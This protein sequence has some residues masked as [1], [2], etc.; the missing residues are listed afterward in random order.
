M[1][2]LIVEDDADTRANLEDILSLDG[3]CVR[4]AGSLKEA[5]ARD[6][7]SEIGVVLLDRKLP[8]S[9]EENAI[10][11]VKSAAPGADVMIVTGYRDIEGAIECLRC[12]AADYILKPINPELLRARV[13][14]LAEHRLLAAEKRRG[15]AVFRGVVEAAECLIVIV[16]EDRS[17]AYFSP[18][19]ERLT[20]F[21][22]ADV[23]GHEY[24]ELF[25][26]EQDQGGTALSLERALAGE[27]I[28]GFESVVWCRDGQRRWLLWN[29]IRLDDYEGRMAVLC[30]GQDITKRKA[31]EE[32]AL[33]AERLA[34]IGQMMTGLAHESRN[35][36]QRSRACL[37]LLSL[38]VEGLPEALDLV[39]RVHKAQDDLQRLFEEVREY[40]A[41]IHLSRQACWL[42]NAWQ[43]AWS[44]LSLLRNGRQ[45]EL[46]AP[47]RDAS[48][49]VH[50]D[51]FALGQVFR[52]V[53]E[54]AIAACPAQQKTTIEIGVAPA[55]L[56]GRP[57]VRLAIRDNGPGMTNEQE[58]RI[59][60]PFYTTKT[61]GTGLGMAIVK[62][63]LDA[64]EG[65]VF[66]GHGNHQ[67]A[68][69]VFVLPKG[70]PSKE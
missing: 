55:V 17:V 47:G 62:R 67:G 58:Q 13:N 23:V 45:V 46:R 6:D 30:V 31:A 7:W 26:A 68:E 32:R 52:N 15:D 28:H 2:I 50:A 44:D 64:H 27:P 19:A 16:L 29:A 42:D 14:R 41:P 8:D 24:R 38:E 40:A 12:G 22:A 35:A 56:D 39:E 65:R 57:A 33:Q 20:G 66:V 54:N 3:H 9:G 34:A 25:L 37:E 51:P 63:I 11:R 43:Q 36:L 4:C 61:K 48:M 5:F 60:E 1:N 18:F 49:C 70:D 10:A 59:F 53:F 69:I 21:R